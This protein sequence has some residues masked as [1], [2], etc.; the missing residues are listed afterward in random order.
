MQALFANWAP[1][2]ERS[3][4][5]A[6]AASGTLFGTLVAF[7]LSGVLADSTFLGGWPAIF[8]VFGKARSLVSHGHN[9]TVVG[10]AGCVWFVFWAVF[11]ESTPSS[12]RWMSKE[13]KGYIVKSLQAEGQV[14]KTR[15]E[16]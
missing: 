9:M 1:P 10:I 11:V 12:H 4:L 16:T 2:T 13:E 15:S 6:F 5:P 8:Y 14:K 3:Q 7:M